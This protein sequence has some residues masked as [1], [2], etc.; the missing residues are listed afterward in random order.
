MANNYNRQVFKLVVIIC[1]DDKMVA[2]SQID[3]LP[4]FRYLLADDT[5]FAVFQNGHNFRKLVIA[6]T[7]VAIIC[8]V[9]PPLRIDDFNPAWIPHS[10]GLR[11]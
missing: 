5:D 4:A 8:V 1:F 2:E 10:T 3:S 9:K 11:K 6:Y 7:I